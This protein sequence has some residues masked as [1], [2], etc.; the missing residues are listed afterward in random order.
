MEHPDIQVIEDETVA[1]GFLKVRRFKMR[2]RKFDGGWTDVVTREVC[3]R[4]HAVAVLLYDPDR[5]AVVMVEQFRIGVAYAGDPGWM[6][7]IVAGSVKPGEPVEDVAR[8]E[9]LEEAGVVVDELV[10]ICDFYPSP[11]GLSEHVYVFCA[12]VD[13]STVGTHGG[14]EEEHE[15]IRLH[16]VP[17]DE[18]IRLL[19]ENR[20]NNSVTIIAFAWLARHKDE[21]RRQW[22]EK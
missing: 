21:L 19:D 4:G 11:G 14:L 10:N 2:H 6:M 5:D 22:V 13:S 17:C 3:D 18:A 1:K 9:T 8:R 20:L 16:V 15:D 12:R 7:E